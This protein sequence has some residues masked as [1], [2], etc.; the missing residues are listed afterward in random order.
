MFYNDL[1]R[2]KKGFLKYS[3]CITTL[4]LLFAGLTCASDWTQFQADHQHNAVAAGPAP[5]EDVELIWTAAVSDDGSN[6]I[7]VPPVIGMEQVYVVSKNG[8]VW[9]FDRFTGELSWKNKATSGGALQSSTP[10]L[11]EDKIIVATFNGELSAYDRATGEVM[12]NTKVTDGSF[13]CPLTC[14]EGLIYIGEG[15]KG[16]VGPKSYYCYNEDGQPVWEYQLNESAGFL[17]NGAVVVG[18]YIVFSSHEGVLFSLNK[19]TGEF[20]DRVDLGLDDISFSKEDP[21][22]FRCSVSYFDGY[23]YTA[24]ERGQETG[25][26]WKVGFNDGHFIDD[27]WCTHNGFSTSTPVVC[28]GIVY[29][30]QGE[31]G[32][33]GNLTGL[34]D[35]TGEVLWSYFVDAGVKSSPA[36][37]RESGVTYAYFTGAKNDGMLYCV[38]EGGEPVWSFD[39][40]DTG[41]ILQGAAI[42]DGKVFFA[43]DAG[44]LY[45]L[46]IHVDPAW[47]QFHKD[48]LH[49]GYSPSKTPDTAELLWSGE[50]IGAIKGSSPVIEDGMVFV[51]CGEVVRSLDA[52]TG[53]LLGNH[54]NGSTKY[55]SIASPVYHEG[56]TWCGLPDSVNSGSTILGNRVYEGV[57]DGYYYCTDINTGEVLWNFTAEGNAQATPAYKDGHIYFT[58]WEYG[59]NYSGNVYCVDADSGELVWHQNKIE[60]SCSGSPAIYG[61]IVYVTTFNFYGNGDIFALDANDGSILWNHSIQRT[62]S[63]P[64]VGYGN[65]YVAGGSYGYSDLYTYCFDAETGE[66][67]WNTSAEDA[68]GG[69]L[70]SVAVADGKVFSGTAF[71]AQ[72]DHNGL[73]GICALDA[74]T[75]ELIWN[76]PDGGST[77]AVSD[78]VVYTIGEDGRVYAYGQLEEPEEEVPSNGEDTAKTTPGFG[79]LS[80]IAGSIALF[81]LRRM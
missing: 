32:Y 74:F 10:A 5:V 56:D 78:G 80:A 65:V 49:T 60:R 76:A 18:E 12:W 24:S 47:E 50:D 69:W 35:S 40:K 28:D 7:S 71:G 20:V 37:V 3:I 17:W 36:V 30:G 64:A 9:A 63:T 67:I 22:M 19:D 46:G 44:Y 48:L 72:E 11:T 73:R 16:G 58:S 81:Y 52:R 41:Y 54:S 1:M 70:C 57:W 14:Y 13:E 34:D 55:D 66:L 2:R 77:P 45:C 38:N 27:G 79:I 4:I 51:N 26:V 23:V 39:P 59:V 53:E 15:L 33:T 68:I 8:S 6:G 31:H 21:G 29:V 61:D 62:S 25:Y 75:G 43:T 42:A